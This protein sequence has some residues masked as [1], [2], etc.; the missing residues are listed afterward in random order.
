MNVSE[1]EHGKAAAS[2]SKN[3]Y[4]GRRVARAGPG[5]AG[6]AAPSNLLDRAPPVSGATPLHVTLLA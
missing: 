5:R 6:R 2:G 1:R 3:E 4:M